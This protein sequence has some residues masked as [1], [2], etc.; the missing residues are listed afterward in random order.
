MSKLLLEFDNLKNP[1]NTE[2]EKMIVDSS[3]KCSGIAFFFKIDNY[4][5]SGIHNINGIFLA[6][7]ITSLLNDHKE[8][9]TILKMSGVI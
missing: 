1:M 4:G 2:I 7:I 5:A 6:A 9:R 8:V 3:K